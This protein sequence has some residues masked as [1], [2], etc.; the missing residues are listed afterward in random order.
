[1]GSI[2]LLK[3][4][5]YIK[6]FVNERNDEYEKFFKEYISPA[7]EDIK[8]VYADIWTSLYEIEGE[9][10]KDAIENDE[11]VARLK[12]ARIPY[13]KTGACHY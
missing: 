7:Y 13:P 12:Q 9:L 8:T 3:I 6:I 5:D 1:M 2:D 11:A 10:Q 4:V